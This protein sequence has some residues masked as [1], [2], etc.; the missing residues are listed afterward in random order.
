MVLFSNAAHFNLNIKNYVYNIISLLL[1]NLN[2]FLF[3]F[4]LKEYDLFFKK[5]SILDF[6]IPT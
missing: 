1:K 4:I 5:K 6:T 2:S 3:D